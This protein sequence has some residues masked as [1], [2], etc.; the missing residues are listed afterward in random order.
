MNEE[1]R[2]QLSPYSRIR[3]LEKENPG[4]LCCLRVFNRP[5]KSNMF[6]PGLNIRTKQRHGRRT[7]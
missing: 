4:V 6:R 1:M 2:P 7:D 5:L 3:D